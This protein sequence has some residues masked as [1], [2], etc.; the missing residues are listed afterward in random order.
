MRVSLVREKSIK[1]GM[2]RNNVKFSKGDN[3]H[4]TV[5]RYTD[6]C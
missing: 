6:G 5:I 1:K 3:L 4:A 2:N